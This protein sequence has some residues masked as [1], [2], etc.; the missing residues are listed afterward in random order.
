MDESFCWSFVYSN[1]GTYFLGIIC[2]WRPAVKKVIF[3][4]HFKNREGE[5]RGGGG[6][7]RRGRGGREEVS[8]EAQGNVCAW[9]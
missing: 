6:R 5:R 4:L 2:V 7:R 3:T 8:M 9:Q 1:L